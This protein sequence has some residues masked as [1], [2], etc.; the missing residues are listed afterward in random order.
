MHPPKPRNLD[1]YLVDRWLDA[2]DS[3]KLFLKLLPSPIERFHLLGGGARE[4]EEDELRDLLL[5]C[6][7]AKVT[8]GA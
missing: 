5:Y 3:M 8:H 1:M 4:Q 6:M 7:R 2:E